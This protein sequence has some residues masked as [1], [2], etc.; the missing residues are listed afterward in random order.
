MVRIVMLPLL[1]MDTTTR[2]DQTVYTFVDATIIAV[3]RHTP[4]ARPS[5]YS[6]RWFTPDLKA[7]RK[8]TERAESSKKAVPSE[9][10]IAQ[11]Q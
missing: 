7:Q 10:N 9:E 8:S 1:E 6:K 2:L 11:L 4:Q 3:E 5:P